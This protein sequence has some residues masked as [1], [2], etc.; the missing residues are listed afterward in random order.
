MAKKKAAKAAK[1]PAAKSAKRGIT[2]RVGGTRVEVENSGLE[3]WLYDEA[4][5]DAIATAGP[6]DEGSGGM[7]PRFERS[8][9][10]GL[11]V[12]YSLYQDDGVDCEVHVGADFSEKEL[13]VGRWLEPQRAFLRLPS[14]TLC[15][16]SNDASRVGPEEPG[17]KGATVKVPPGDYRLTLLRVDH[18]ALDREE[19]EWDGPQELVLLSPGGKPADAATALL[20]FEHRRDLSFVGKHRIEDSRADV[21]VWFGDYWDTYFV[22]LDTAACAKLGLTPGRHFRIVV[23]GAGITLVS[24]FGPTW[25]EARRLPPPSNIALDEY[26][27]A[28]VITAQDWAPHETL[29]GRRDTTK[30][31]AEA[32]FHNSW[33]R[34]TL[35]VLDAMAHPPRAPSTEVGQIDLAS[36]QFFQD[37]FLP[38]VLGD[39]LPGVEDLEA[40]S[41]ADAIAQVDKAVAK[42]GLEPQ[43]DIGWMQDTGAHHQEVG[44][45][46]YAGA[47]DHFAAIIAAEGSFEFVF[48][49]ELLDGNWVVTGLADEIDRRIQRSG[50]TGLPL[51][52]P[53]VR[54]TNLDEPI[55]RIHA[56]HRKAL[57]KAKTAGAPGD[58]IESAA[59][60]TRFLEVATG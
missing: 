36:K 10:Q 51:P 46:L 60:L 58:F 57:G 27:Y 56:A 33:I 9:K 4:N 25:E 1:R 53:R 12:G 15:I 50:P 17:A 40:L 35:E 55:S 19:R 32:R 7:P 42:S 41:L 52:H 37:D 38:L 3:V 21:L 5:R 34:G 8:T 20:P 6:P 39:F 43:G 47:D 13:S 26:G 54:L 30:T 48:L 31:R 45:R 44:V 11:I 59:A 18:E 29:F 2:I 24:V 14:G 23:P 28:S 49:S 22:N 16:E